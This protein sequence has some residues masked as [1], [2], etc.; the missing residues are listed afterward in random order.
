MEAK[1]IKYAN[2]RVDIYSGSWGPPD[3]GKALD[4][5][6]HLSSVAFYHGI[7]MVCI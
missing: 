4:G 6:G 5:P 7:T 3:N 2:D 1:A